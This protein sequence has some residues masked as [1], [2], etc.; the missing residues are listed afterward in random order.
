MDRRGFLRMMVGGVAAAAAVR[1]FPFRVFSFPEKI[2][3][4]NPCLTMDQ[5]RVSV[6]LLQDSAFD[7]ERFVAYN[8]A[9]RVSRILDAHMRDILVGSAI[10]EPAGILQAK[11]YELRA[12]S[13]ELESCD[14][15][16]R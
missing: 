14:G 12:V 4:A 10:S 15:P 7:I 8:F 3:L 16:P 13:C 9:Y 2:Q 6:E 5:V 11:S 1:T